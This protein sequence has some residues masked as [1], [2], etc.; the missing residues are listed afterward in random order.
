MSGFAAV[1][2]RG[3]SMLELVQIIKENDVAKFAVI[4]YSDYLQICH[5]LL[6]EENLEDY[7]DYL[8]AQKVKQASQA[9]VPIEEAK[10]VLGLN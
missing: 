4:P 7:L 8:H 1:P 2:M 10:Q 3:K 5:L 6:D 9:W